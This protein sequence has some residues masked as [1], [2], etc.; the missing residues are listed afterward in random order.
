VNKEWLAK[1]PD[2]AIRFLTALTQA[3]RSM[4]QN[5]ADTIRIAAKAT[6]FNEGVIDKTYEVLL[7]HNRVFPVNDGLEEGRLAYTIT[8]MKSLGLLKDKAPDLVQL[9]DR[10]PFMQVLDKLGGAER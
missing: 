9:V 10:R 1:N 5:R 6:G 2:L 4:Y 8:R 7:V 3:H